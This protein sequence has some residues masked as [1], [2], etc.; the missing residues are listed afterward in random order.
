MLHIL[1]NIDFLSLFSLT[2]YSEIIIDSYIVAREC[3]MN[4]LL[5]VIILLG[6]LQNL[7]SFHYFYEHSFELSVFVFVCR[8]VYYIS[9]ITTTTIKIQNCSVIEEL[10]NSHIL[11]FFNCILLCTL[12]PC[13]GGHKSF[14]NL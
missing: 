13:S 1:T 10:R 11:H 12:S 9:C 14:L 4:L 3:I 7:F 5:I 6:R 2:F 8:S